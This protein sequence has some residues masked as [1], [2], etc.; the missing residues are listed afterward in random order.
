MPLTAWQGK[1]N[2]TLCRSR[3][4]SKKTGFDETVDSRYEGKY[5]ISVMK[6]IFVSRMIMI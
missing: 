5:C 2:M 6:L 3:S 4:I 1:Y